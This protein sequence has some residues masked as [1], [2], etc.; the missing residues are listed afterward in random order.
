MVEQQ[1]AAMEAS[2]GIHL[3][4]ILESGIRLKKKLAL[5]DKF[6]GRGGG[7]YSYK[8]VDIEILPNNRVE[9]MIPSK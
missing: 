2:P 4:F 3:A 6:G 5:T 8:R 7:G 1:T 9:P